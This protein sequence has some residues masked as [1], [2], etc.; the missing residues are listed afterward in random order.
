VATIIQPGDS[1]TASFNDDS[2]PDTRQT[3]G[4]KLSVNAQVAPESQLDWY[5]QVL[6]L[7]ESIPGELKSADVWLRF[8]ALR[9]EDKA[10]IWGGLS[11][12]RIHIVDPRPYRKSLEEIL[13]T[14][15]PYNNP[16]TFLQQQAAAKV[17]WAIWLSEKGQV[18]TAERI[19]SDSMGARVH[20]LSRFLNDVL[21]MPLGGDSESVEDPILA[22]SN[23]GRDA[24]PLV[25][26]ASVWAAK[27]AATFHEA[28]DSFLEFDETFRYFP[29]EIIRKRMRSRV[30][31]THTFDQG[32]QT[33]L[34]LLET[35]RGNILKKLAEPGRL[36]FGA[37]AKPYLQTDSKNSFLVQ[38]ADI[39]AGIASKIVETQN[40]VAVVS[41]FEYVT[42]NGRRISANDA[43]EEMRQ[44][45]S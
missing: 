18:Y 35:A 8:Q 42:Y 31:K 28:M 10:R 11:K 19:I 44:M 2:S 20:R 32:G 12:V 39:A 6:Q 37:P 45:R 1:D 24:R 38:A 27:S 43:E 14:V 36:E 16:I 26:K 34:E 25:R 13:R 5:Y 29:N 15:L 30:L 17:P 9:G 3:A 22:L 40:L 33:H 23:F 21:T 4:Q 7:C 41:A